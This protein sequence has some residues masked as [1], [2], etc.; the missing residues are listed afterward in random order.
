MFFYAKKEITEGGKIFFMTKAEAK[1]I[2]ISLGYET[3]SVLSL[4][5]NYFIFRNKSNL[6][7]LKINENS[8]DIYNLKDSSY[9]DIVSAGNILLKLVN[10]ASETTELSLFT[11]GYNST[12]GKAWIEETGDELGTFEIIKLSDDDLMELCIQNDLDIK[13]KSQ[14]YYFIVEI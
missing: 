5:K 4:K 7:M 3:S 12:N 9:T 11:I 14:I 6:F 1:D 8:A 13:R 2:V 10:K